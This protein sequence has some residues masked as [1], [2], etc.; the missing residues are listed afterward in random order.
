MLNDKQHSLVCCVL[1]ER[2]GGI[3][4]DLVAELRWGGVSHKCQGGKVGRCPICHH[5]AD[6][7]GVVHHWTPTIVA[8]SIPLDV[9]S[10]GT[11][12]VHHEVSWYGGCCMCVL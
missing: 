7:N 4:P 6:F 1:G 9:E 3:V 12:S 5:L 10:K 2:E 11:S 8:G